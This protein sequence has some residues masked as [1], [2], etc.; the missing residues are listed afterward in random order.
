M[1]L[2]FLLTDYVFANTTL[3]IVSFAYTGM[4]VA[5]R[6]VRVR[7]ALYK[8]YRMARTFQLCQKKIL[9]YCTEAS[10]ARPR[11]HVKMPQQTRNNR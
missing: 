7:Y 11:G 3:R 8:N 6:G 1:L 5:R 10:F 4:S 9:Y 2:I